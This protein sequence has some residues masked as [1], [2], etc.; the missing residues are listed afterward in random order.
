MSEVYVPTGLH[1]MVANL[2][3]SRKGRQVDRQKMVCQDTPLSTHQLWTTI[4]ATPS[5]DEKIDDPRF[6]PQ[7]LADTL[8]FAFSTSVCV[9]LAAMFAQIC[10][11]SDLFASEMTLLAQ[12]WAK[13]AARCTA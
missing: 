2:S 10:A 8:N 7:P 9:Y 6:A 4:L 13:I 3:N 5:A 1:Y 11:K 12:T